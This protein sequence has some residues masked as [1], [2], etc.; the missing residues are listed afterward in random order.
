MSGSADKHKTGESAPAD[1]AATPANPFL[2]SAAAFAAAATVGIQFQRQL[3]NTMLG[4]FETALAGTRNEGKVEDVP[5]EDKPAEPVVAPVETMPVAAVAPE[6]VVEPVKLAKATPVA[7]AKP[8]VVVAK[9]PVAKPAAPK[10]PARRAAAIPAPAAEVPAAPVRKS[11]TAKDDLKQLPGVGPKLEQVLNGKGITRFADIAGW[12]EDDVRRIDAELGFDG[13][14]DRDD[15]VGHA[16]S[17]T[18]G[19]KA[20]K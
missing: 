13:R 1:K 6:P 15:W 20:R 18:G 3:A 17:L 10:T 9:A 8:T 7:K 5:V 12:S 11:R 19:R 2:Q 14:I 16:K 4:F